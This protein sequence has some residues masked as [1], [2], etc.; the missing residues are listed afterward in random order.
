MDK[1]YSIFHQSNK[2]QKELDNIS[3]ELTLEIIKIGRVLGP[4]WAACSLRA[5]LA[6]WRSY[7]AL[8]KFFSSN[9]NQKFFGMAKRLQNKYFL[10][11]LALMI[12]I[13]QECS[14][15]SNAL[16]A[17]NINICRGEQLIRRTINA[18]QI[19]KDRRG[20]YE[21]KVDEVINSEVFK[22]ITFVENR[23]YGNLPRDSLIDSIIKNL[24]LRF[25][26]FSQVGSNNNKKNIDNSK[27]YELAN[28]LEP[29]TWKIEDIVVPW[30]EAEEKFDEF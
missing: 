4:R 14:L 5:A 7:P 15:L 17:R 24:K 13:L 27:I 22:N 16:Q 1:L 12:D 19:L 3:Q 21:K 10:A 2:N 9:S 25:I 20:N 18:F 6:V 28:L 29:S 11:D 23:I 30:L 26:S 8:Y